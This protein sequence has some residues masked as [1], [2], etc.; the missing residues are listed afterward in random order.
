MSDAAADESPKVPPELGLACALLEAYVRKNQ[1]PASDMP[2]AI[3]MIYS[4]LTRL[5]SAPTQAPHFGK[6]AVPVKKSL[7][8]DYL[9]C[10][11]DGRKLSMLK[12][13]LRTRHGLSLDQYR[14]K[15][16]LPA[17][18]PMTAPSL[19]QDAFGAG[20]AG[21][22]GPPSWNEMRD[23]RRRALRA[24]CITSKQLPARAGYAPPPFDSC[25][26]RL[27]RHLTFCGENL[28]HFAKWVVHPPKGSHRPTRAN[29]YVFA[30]SG[31][32]PK[33]S[34][35]RPPSKGHAAQGRSAP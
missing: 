17:N 10:L 26:S 32:H 20:Q 1:L 12:R 13:H 16:G 29:T 11:E 19:R 7:A 34:A 27:R 3:Q 15:W 33:V 4:A 5:Q 8:D 9:L 21:R 35:D 2:A 31:T 23:A 14:A 6:P 22:L 25:H 18:Y 24:E 30:H 28:S